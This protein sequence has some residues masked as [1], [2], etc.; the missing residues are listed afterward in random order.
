[1]F[2]SGVLLV[3][4]SAGP[5][6]AQT[7]KLVSKQLNLSRDIKIGHSGTLD[8]FAT[9]LLVVLLG[10]A[11]RLAD[12]FQA[13]IK[14]Y[15]GEIQLGLTTDSDDI[16]GKE[17]SSSEVQASYE[18][19]QD[20]A[21][22]FLGVFDQMPPSVSAL[23][24]NGKRAYNLVRAGEEPELKPRKV[25]LFS[26]ELGALEQTV[27]S[28]KITCSKGFYVRA[29]ARDIGNHLGCGA[30][31][32]SL[33]RLESA[34][35]SVASARKVEELGTDGAGA[36][37]SLSQAFEL[38]GIPE[39]SLPSSYARHLKNGLISD[40]FRSD[41]GPKLDSYGQGLIVYRDA[42]HEQALGLLSVSQQD[43]KILLNF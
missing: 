30:C 1:M 34:P 18:Q 24:V 39:L 15:S 28:F 4:K 7:L 37:L 32:K 40:S 31:L 3:D 16:T 25:Q 2:E 17:I 21:E 9:G 10:K 43:I 11:C 23:K 36:F 22:S 41:F 33:R 35:F 6:S 8:P 38:L 26:I 20:V 5:S 42:E 14:V 12:Y 29:L 27:L 13:G 19:L